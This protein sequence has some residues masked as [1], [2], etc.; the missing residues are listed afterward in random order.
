M[1]GERRYTRRVAVVKGG[2]VELGR[3]VYTFQE[4]QAE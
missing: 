2:K 1:N 3:L 4:P